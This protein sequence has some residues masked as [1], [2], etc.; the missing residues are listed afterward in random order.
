MLAPGAC[1]LR[2]DPPAFGRIERPA[3]VWCGDVVRGVVGAN[4]R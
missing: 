2:I 3:A 4:D 1:R